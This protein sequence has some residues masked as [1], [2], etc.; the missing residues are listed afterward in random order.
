MK[1]PGFPKIRSI[2]EK[3]TLGISKAKDVREDFDKLKE[4]A[5]RN[6][7]EL[8]EAVELLRRVSEQHEELESAY[9]ALLRLIAET[10]PKQ[11]MLLQS[12]ELVQKTTQDLEEALKKHDVERFS[13]IV[14]DSVPRD[15]CKVVGQVET[16]RLF[17]GSVAQVISEGWWIR[18]T[19]KILVFPTVL[20]SIAPPGKKPVSE[21]TA[22]IEAS[23]AKGRISVGGER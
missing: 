19:G 11:E 3:L 14:G 21:K 9:Y 2:P 1:K 13:P 4:Q 22:D 15:K 10:L 8:Q 23:D 7:R 17:P 20:E 5:A 6:Q 18:K 12:Y 16:D